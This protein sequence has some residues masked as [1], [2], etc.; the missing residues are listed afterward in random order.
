MTLGGEM[1]FGG[2]MTLGSE[3]KFSG[4]MKMDD[5]MTIGGEMTLGGEMNRRWNDMAK[6]ECWWNGMA[7]KWHGGEMVGVEMPPNLITGMVEI[8]WCMVSATS[9]FDPSIYKFIGPKVLKN[10]IYTDTHLLRVIQYD[11][12]KLPIFL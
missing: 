8:C 1:T 11:W 6:M 12:K 5:K 4:G 2:E 10:F 3:R 7:V 9:R